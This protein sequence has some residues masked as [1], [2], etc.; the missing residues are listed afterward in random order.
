MLPSAG[1]LI[2]DSSVR[3]SKR[4]GVRLPRIAIVGTGFVGSTTAYAL[5]ISGMAAEIVLGG[6]DPCRTEGHVSDLRDAAVFSYRTRVF[7]GNFDDC[8]S[9]DVTFVTAGVSQVGAKS[10]LEGL[11]ETAAILKDLVGEISRQSPHG[12]V[13]IASRR[14]HARAELWL[15]AFKSNRL[16]LCR[17]Q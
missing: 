7:A 11:Q 16:L 15:P 17:I 5:L 13:L 2:H 1:D 12:I 4:A 9:A 14:S 6:R 10:R 8:C 3:N